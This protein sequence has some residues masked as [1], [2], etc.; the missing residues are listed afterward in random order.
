MSRLTELRQQQA[1]AEQ[2]LGTSS[3]A[4][5]YGAYGM[6]DPAAIPPP[7][8]RTR[9]LAGVQVDLETSLMVDA[10]WAAARIIDSSIANLGNPTPFEWAFDKRNRPYHDWQLP[11]DYPILSNTFASGWQTEGITQTVLSLVLMGEAVWLRLPLSRGQEVVEVLHPAFLQIKKNQQGNT[12]YVY[13]SGE[14][15]TELDPRQVLHAKGMNLPASQRALNPL[16]Y[17]AMDIALM[18]ASLEF[19][20]RFFSQGASPGYALTTNQ[21]PSQEELDRLTQSFIINHAGLT[22]AHLPLV[23]TGGMTA[24]K[25][26]ATPDE[27]QYLNTITHAQ[28]SV[29]ATFGIPLQLMGSAGAAEK[30]NPYGPGAA[31]ELGKVFNRYTMAKYL[32]V[33]DELYSKLLPPKVFS[34]FNRRKLAQPDTVSQAQET[35]ALRNTQVKSINDLR[36]DI[37]EEAPLPDPG[38]DDPLAPLASN[39]A[40]EQTGDKPNPPTPAEGATQLGLQKPESDLKP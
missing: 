34:H 13:G 1:Q 30:G 40:P 37:Y 38:A 27:A 7:N 33:M 20:A 16:N 32:A 6:V 22:N 24:T 19:G 2:R 17:G 18:L 14:N 39:T 12:V 31:E 8:M 5:T 9:Q 10:V 21:T 25:M 4:S 29:A 3:I 28:A 23:L 15:A 11:T 35:T 26:Q 36:V